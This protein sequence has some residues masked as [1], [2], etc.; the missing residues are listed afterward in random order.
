MKKPI[1]LSN[2][3][4]WSF[5]DISKVIMVY[6]LLSWPSSFRIFIEHSLKQI[7]WFI[8]ILNWFRFL[9]DKDVQLLARQLHK[10]GD[11]NDSL[12]YLLEQNSTRPNILFG[13]VSCCCCFWGLVQI[14]KLHRIYCASFFYCFNFFFFVIKVN[15]ILIITL[16]WTLLTQHW[17]S[18]PNYL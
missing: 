7:K 16:N 2:F 11:F 10:I 12:D 3:P 9:Y 1:S 8:S 15:I 14:L 18:K 4:W 17:I 13:G 6:A 5:I